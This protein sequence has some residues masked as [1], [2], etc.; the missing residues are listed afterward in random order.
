V[1]SPNRLGARQPSSC[2]CELCSDTSKNEPPKCQLCIQTRHLT[3]HPLE[4]L[5]KSRVFAL[6]SN[7][8][9]PFSTR[10]LCFP[11]KN[12]TVDRDLTALAPYGR[13]QVQYLPDEDRSWTYAKD[14]PLSLVNR[15][16]RCRFKPKSTMRF[17]LSYF[18]RY[19][20]FI[21]QNT[22][23]VTHCFQQFLFTSTMFAHV[24][25]FE[26][27]GV[28]LAKGEA[29]QNP[30]IFFISWGGHEWNQNEHY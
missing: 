8:K 27:N 5:E 16:R 3:S 29:S 11:E 18:C 19:T 9:P 4:T 2:V 7:V 12:G 10:V 30:Q 17:V 22:D 13:M 15:L 14:Q 25:S 1:R 24:R 20:Q 23:L 6:K 28:N 21:G 26:F